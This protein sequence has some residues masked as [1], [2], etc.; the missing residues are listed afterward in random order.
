LI[1]GPADGAHF[2]ERFLAVSSQW[3]RELVLVHLHSQRVRRIALPAWVSN[4]NAVDVSAERVLLAGW[5]DPQRADLL[6]DHVKW[7]LLRVTFDEP[8]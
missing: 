6:Y 4:I 1:L 2:S 5:R 7:F 8:L 3:S